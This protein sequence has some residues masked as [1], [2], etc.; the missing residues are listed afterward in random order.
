MRPSS[1]N[2]KRFAYYRLPVIAL[3]AAIF[4]Q[5][6]YPG[7]IEEPLFSHDDKVIH[8][9]T[10]ALLAMLAA[11]SLQKERPWL[12]VLKIGFAA[13]LFACFYGLTD[14]IHQFFVPL[15][16]ASAMDFAADCLGSAAGA[17]FYCAVFLTRFKGDS[18]HTRNL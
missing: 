9:F 17:W 4:W 7:I 5:S 11:R 16:T 1:N 2:L 6:S 14:E 3:C 10:Y 15:R 8:F 12:P 13:A 18:S